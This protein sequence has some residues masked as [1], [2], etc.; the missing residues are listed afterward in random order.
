[1]LH[2]ICRMQTNTIFHSNPYYYISIATNVLND[3]LLSLAG[4]ATR[5]DVNK[6]EY[7]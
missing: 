5:A 7:S 1:M 6:L 4:I 2:M 3:F